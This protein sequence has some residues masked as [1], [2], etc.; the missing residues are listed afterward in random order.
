[1][2]LTS[3]VLRPLC[4]GLERRDLGDIF[5]KTGAVLSFAGLHVDQPAGGALGTVGPVSVSVSI[6]PSRSRVIRL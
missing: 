6:W 5:F 1:M 2:P 4:L 3:G